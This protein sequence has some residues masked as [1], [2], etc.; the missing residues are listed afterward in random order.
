MDLH[1]FQTEMKRIHRLRS[2]QWITF[3]GSY[4]GSLAAW[5]RLKFPESAH[6]ALAASAPVGIVAD[7][8]G[9]YQV[10]ITSLAATHSQHCVD[11]V[12]DATRSMRKLVEGGGTEWILL[13]RA[14]KYSSSRT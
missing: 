14:F 13:K 1:T 7:F 5:Y 12:H 10:V 2:N 3:G 11:A 9:Y 4:A 6:A 8:P